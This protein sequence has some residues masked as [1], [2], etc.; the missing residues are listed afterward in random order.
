MA[1]MHVVVDGSNIA[2]EGRSTPSLK[3]LDEAVRAFLAEHP[4]DK[5]TV[6]VDATFGHRIDGS[7]RKL[8]DDAI[9]NNEMVTPPA[10]A[11]GRGDAFVLEIA[12]RAGATVLS[13]DSFQEFHGMH[14][15]LFDEGRL[16]GGKPVPE[17]GWVFV[18]RSPV[19]GATSQR[20][21][22]EARKKASGASQK[23]ASQEPA[24]TGDAAGS[25]GGGR[26][27]GRSKKATE[28]GAGGSAKGG[29]SGGGSKKAAPKK[30]AS[31]SSTSKGG[32]TAK[33]GTAKGTAKAAGKD[34]ATPAKRTSVNKTN[35]PMAFIEFVANHP[36]GS[37]VT[38][39]VERFS[40]HG[41]YVQAGGARCYVSLKSLGD[42]PPNRARDVVERGEVREFVVLAFDTPRRGIDLILP[43]LPATP[44]PT[45]AEDAQE[46]ATIVDGVQDVPA[47][48][49]KAAKKRGGIAEA[50]KKLIGRKK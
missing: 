48:A 15:W 49:R 5:L 4:H 1:S 24:S 2:T 21:V 8:F 16:I 11:I 7:E 32:D 6:V 46:A 37:T 27:R 19:R 33:G 20:A 30:A 26:G 17:V 25:T 34:A 3:Q 41:A 10:G 50:A 18:P 47:A 43:G 40:S 31:G 44:E 9:A 12:E 45:T 22:R 29:G 28:A 36:V 13:N 35:E 42:P 23:R 14:P 39:E 38:G